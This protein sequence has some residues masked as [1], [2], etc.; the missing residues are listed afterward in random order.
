MSGGEMI[1][2]FIL[3]VHWHDK[4]K[5]FNAILVF[6]NVKSS[7]YFLSEVFGKPN[8]LVLSLNSNKKSAWDSNNNHVSY[9]IH[10]LYEFMFQRQ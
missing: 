1:H 6:F 10:I 4:Y 8:K 5:H 2:I 3:T 7:F 9:S